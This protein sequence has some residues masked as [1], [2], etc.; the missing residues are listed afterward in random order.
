MALRNYKIFQDII[1][2]E[3]VLKKL[4]NISVCGEIVKVANCMDDLIT[5]YGKE[6]D[7]LLQ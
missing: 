2:K 1:S 4:Y 7:G 5:P 3:F 6:L